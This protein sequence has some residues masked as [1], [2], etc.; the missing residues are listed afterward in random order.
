MSLKNFA[1]EIKFSLNTYFV[2]IL[3]GPHPFPSLLFPHFFGGPP[4]TMDRSQEDMRMALDAYH[5]ELA[6]LNTCPSPGLPGLLALQQ[7]GIHQQ[8]PSQQQNGGAQ[9]LSLPKERKSDTP[10][11]P[12]TPGK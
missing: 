8:T 4:G 2:A 3:G 11:P 6:K 1:F 10:G 5:R 12:S 7:Q 9:D